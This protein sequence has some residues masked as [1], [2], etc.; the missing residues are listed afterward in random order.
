MHLAPIDLALIVIDG[1]SPPALIPN[2][3]QSIPGPGQCPHLRS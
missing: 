3:M 2:R 1:S